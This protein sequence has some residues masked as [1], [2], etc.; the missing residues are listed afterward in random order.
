MFSGRKQSFQPAVAQLQKQDSE[1]DP[2][3]QG[4]YTERR[5]SVRR[6]S[7][8]VAVR[9]A[10][11]FAKEE[12][13]D[14]WVLERSAGGLGLLLPNKKAVG[15]IFCVRSANCS[16]A[17]AWVQVEVRN[18]QPMGKE[19]WLLGCKFVSRTPWSLLLQFG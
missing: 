11:A 7:G 8:S 6:G 3:L 5:K 19:G 9:I 18:C 2:L 4:A 10:D 13:C 17:F 14:G 15:Q 16:E 1:A 12:L